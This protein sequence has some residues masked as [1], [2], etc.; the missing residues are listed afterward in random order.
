MSGK[1]AALM[2]AL[3]RVVLNTALSIVCLARRTRSHVHGW[4]SSHKRRASRKGA[5]LSAREQNTQ[6]VALKL[7]IVHW[8]VSCMAIIPTSSITTRFGIRPTMLL[9]I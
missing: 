6:P 9:A 1:C 2:N 8:N 7:C 4:L 3:Q 5:N